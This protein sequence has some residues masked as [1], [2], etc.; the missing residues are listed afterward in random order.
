MRRAILVAEADDVVPEGD[1]GEQRRR[2]NGLGDRRWATGGWL[3]RVPMALLLPAG[4]SRQAI[5]RQPVPALPGRGMTGQ[6]TRHCA[7]VWNVGQ[8]V[9]RL[10]KTIVIFYYPAR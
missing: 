3:G 10:L 7:E 4:G 6:E 5:Q 2:N 1:G 8:G 9:A